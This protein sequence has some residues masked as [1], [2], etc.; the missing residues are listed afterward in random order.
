MNHTAPSTMQLFTAA[1]FCLTP[2]F[3]I[4][5][6]NPYAMPAGTHL[7]YG[8]TATI[9]VE[10]KDEKQNQS[11]AFRPEYTVLNA[12]G[13]MRTVFC[14]LE[15]GNAETATTEP[16]SAAGR[17]TF[18][19]GADGSISERTAGFTPRQM[20]GW[21]AEV[22]FPAFI[23]TD[24]TTAS[25][26]STMGEAVEV[27]VKKSEAD[28]VVTYKLTKID[29]GTSAPE[30][31]AA[32]KSYTATVVYSP[33]DKQVKS[34]ES[35]LE[36]EIP[37]GPIGKATF[38]LEIK[39]EAKERSVIPEAEMP[40]LEKDILAGIKVM[41]TLQQGGMQSGKLPEE[42][43][44]YLKDNPKG[45]FAK[46]FSDLKESFEMQ[47]TMAKNKA[48]LEEGK[49]A[50]DFTAKTVT[51]K[52]VKLSSLKGQVVLL[53]F[54]ASWCGPCL[55]ELPELKNIYE[56]HDGKGLTIIGISADHDEQTLVNFV[57]ENDIKWMQIY[58]ADRKPG[59][60]GTIYGVMS[61]P[62][63]ILIDAK[64]N[65]SAM[66]LRSTELAEAIDKLLEKK[67]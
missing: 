57:K 40:V 2:A 36:A 55:A 17:F 50:P 62:T 4:A 1:L 11:I 22:E 19:I 32:I 41:E 65:I 63:T 54:W 52:E 20:P 9:S 56:K 28:G 6:E 46:I 67:E 43:E 58:D 35:V 44:Q 3:A 30:G 49:P 61:F 51:G 33:T 45:K 29:T 26:N 60:P 47:M 39:S 27:N 13:A 10:T 12:N 5:A 38:K 37:Q 15:A 42:L 59:S 23:G 18:E 7:V 25:V 66:N 31:E 24:A 64:G 14:S 21:N 34:N 8:T 53:D 48:S 16:L